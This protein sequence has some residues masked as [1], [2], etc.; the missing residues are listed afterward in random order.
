MLAPPDPG[1][2]K[3]LEPPAAPAVAPAP[4]LEAPAKPAPVASAPAPST[5]TAL[6][7]VASTAETEVQ[8]SAPPPSVP[9]QRTEFGIDLGSANSLEGLRTMWQRLIK[10]NKTLGALH[11]IVVVKERGTGTQLRLVAGPINDAATAAKLCAGMAAADYFCET[12]LYDG[13]RLSL[14]RS[15]V[16]PQAHQ[17]QSAALPSPNRRSRR[18]PRRRKPQT[19]LLS[20]LGVH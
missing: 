4:E 20:L 18:P 19:S 13:Q 14:P 16:E 5:A 11:P 6:P 8:P 10:S 3:L 2:G 12:T 7:V 1:A 15:A 9:V 17:R